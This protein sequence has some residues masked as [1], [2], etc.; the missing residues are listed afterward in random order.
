MEVTP[1]S[2]WSGSCLNL[3]SSA[4]RK[5]A[6]PESLPCRSSLS[7]RGNASHS[8]AVVFGAQSSSNAKV[9]RAPATSTSM[10]R[11]TGSPSRDVWTPRNVHRWIRD[12]QTKRRGRLR[13]GGDDLLREAL[14]I[15]H[16]LA[17]RLAEE[18]HAHV[19]DA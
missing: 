17:R 18:H 8:T 10:R 1:S 11:L 6:S 13:E 3:G 15:R 4:T 12:G 14:H 16:Q 19:L 7:W 5:A 9:A 2:L